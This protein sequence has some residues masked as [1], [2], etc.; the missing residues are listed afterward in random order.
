M[1]KKDSLRS[2]LRR[3]RKERRHLWRSLRRKVKKVMR[4]ERVS[5]RMGLNNKEN[6]NG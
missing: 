3:I 6:A 2:E 4:L 1:P 5:M